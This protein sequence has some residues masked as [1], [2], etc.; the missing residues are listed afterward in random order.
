MVNMYYYVSDYGHGCRAI[1]TIKALLK[2]KTTGVHIKTSVP[3]EFMRKSLE[4]LPSDIRPCKNDIDF[5]FNDNFKMDKSER[6]AP[7]ENWLFTWNGF[8]ARAIASCRS[9]KNNLILS[10][11][12]PQSLIITEISR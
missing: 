6:E 9:K 7:L 3:F 1:E 4:N 2:E 8:I 5:F 12:L 10:D 11:V